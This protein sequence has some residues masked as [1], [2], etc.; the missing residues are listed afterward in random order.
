MSGAGNKAKEAKSKAILNQFTMS[1][2][3]LQDMVWAMTQLERYRLSHGATMNDCLIASVCQG[4]QIPLYRHN[5][6]DMQLLLGVS[7][8]VRPY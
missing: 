5:L 1:Y 4:L 8:V 6:R 7:Q 3:T 2:P